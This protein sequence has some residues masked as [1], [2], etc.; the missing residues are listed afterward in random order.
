MAKSQKRKYGRG[1]FWRVRRMIEK[2]DI[3]IEVLDARFAEQTRNPA[4]E[5]FIFREDKKLVL[6]I[7]KADLVSRTYGKAQMKKLQRAADAPC[8]LFSAKK[9]YGTKK[10]RTAIGRASVGKEV[11]LCIIGYPNTGK[12]SLINILRGKRVAGIGREPGFTRGQQYVSLTK[13]IMLIDTPGVIPIQERDE[14]RLALLGA[15]SPGQLG[16]VKEVA[17]R[18][19]LF[20][21]GQDPEALAGRYRLQPREIQ[22]QAHEI[23][24]SIAVARKKLRKGA[25]PDTNAAA[26]ILIKDWQENRLGT[27]G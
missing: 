20:L 22:G 3:V 10:L 8:V 15:K 4:L 27:S 14:F 16:D 23:L 12:S 9:R 1:F 19:I 7:N 5:K 2:S 11:K 17:E 21:R 6:V 13:K 25:E 24:E 18:L 26:R